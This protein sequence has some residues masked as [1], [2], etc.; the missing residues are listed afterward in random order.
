MGVRLRRP[1]GKFA[2][3]N[4]VT[5]ERRRRGNVEM[6]FSNQ[7][8]VDRLVDV[9]AHADDRIDQR[10]RFRIEMLGIQGRSVQVL[11]DVRRIPERQI[12]ETFHRAGEEA[13]E[14]IVVERVGDQPVDRPVDHRASGGELLFRRQP[15][16]FAF[17]RVEIG[18]RGD[19]RVHRLGGGKDAIFAGG[20][21]FAEDVRVVHAEKVVVGGRIRSNLG[22][23]ISHDIVSISVG[24]QLIN[25]IEN[26]RK[27]SLFAPSQFQQEESS[28]AIPEEI[29]MR[30]IID[31]G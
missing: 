1:E 19:E 23:E 5:V 17:E 14:R 21:G 20:R 4:V 27:C 6:C 12:V 9:A 2:L 18:E 8:L 7:L 13:V 30:W 28:T 26:V 25:P 29:V 31:L 10:L 15:F 24:Q 16:Q 3:R 22:A 11:I